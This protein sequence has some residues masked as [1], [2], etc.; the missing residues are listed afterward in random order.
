MQVIS[1]A[2]TKGSDSNIRPQN[3][4]VML[5]QR[6][7][8]EQPLSESERSATLAA[9]GSQKAPSGYMVL[10]SRIDNMLRQGRPERA[11]VEKLAQILADRIA[12]LG[13]QTRRS[14]LEIS[15][16]K[17]LG[18]DNLTQLPQTITAHIY[19]GTQREA[20]MGLLR[21]PTF[22]AAIKDEFRIATYGPK[23]LLRAS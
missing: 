13:P 3:A 16:V 7:H 6:P 1:S 10:I 21:E 14:L 17:A 19:A 18:V 22:A 12:R 20:V 15:Q 2:V 11:S 9:E 23:G 4:D 5:R 8:Q